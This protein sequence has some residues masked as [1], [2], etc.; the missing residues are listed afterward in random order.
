M[1]IHS[2][3]PSSDGCMDNLI[4]CISASIPSCLSYIKIYYFLFWW[5][6]YSNYILY[7]Y[8]RSQT[9]SRMR[10]TRQTDCQSW[11]SNW[12]VLPRR[13]TM[14][15]RGRSTSGVKSR[16]PRGSLRETSRFVRRPRTVQT[17]F[18]HKSWWAHQTPDD[19]TMTSS[20]LQDDF[21]MTSSDFI[22]TSPWLHHDFHHDVIIKQTPGNFIIEFLTL[23]FQHEIL[24][25]CDA[26]L[27]TICNPSCL[28]QCNVQC[29]MLTLQ[30]FLMPSNILCTICSCLHYHKLVWP[31]MHCTYASL[32]RVLKTLLKISTMLKLIWRRL[33]PGGWLID[34]LS[35][36]WLNRC[37]LSE[38]LI[39][40]S[41]GFD[42][43][44]NSM[45]SGRSLVSSPDPQFHV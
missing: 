21:I 28:Y 25:A 34:W 10:R 2:S 19:L 45:S 42:G 29:G 40:P 1:G 37:W 33:W 27:P 3:E 22:M 9:H 23:K 26:F 24:C 12:R 6:S 7:I 14:S 15:L 41:K 20:W 17:I 4:L 8:R 31:I 30:Y 36:C 35:D 5:C 38:G 11:R 39:S 44:R 18:E 13:F 16:R 32:Y 43:F